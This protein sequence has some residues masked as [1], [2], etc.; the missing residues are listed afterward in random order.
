[1]SV[2]AICWIKVLVSHSKK[3]RGPS[4]KTMESEMRSCIRNGQDGRERTRCLFTGWVVMVTHKK[5]V[6]FSFSR[7]SRKFRYA[8]TA[9]SWEEKNSILKVRVI[10]EYCH[11]FAIPQPMS[12]VWNSML[13]R[14]TV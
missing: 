10:F 3:R 5:E 9:S 7:T 8:N 11:D 4:L 12:L 13:W 1:M 2:D 6:F 14:N